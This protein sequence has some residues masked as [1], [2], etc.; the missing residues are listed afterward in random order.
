[1]DKN[2]LIKKRVA[3]EILNISQ[4]ILD[5]DEYAKVLNY[6]NTNRINDLRLFI[7]EKM[8]FYDTLS[9]IDNEDEQIKLQ[10]KLC[11]KLENIIMEEF[12]ENV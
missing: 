11:D 2:I 9:I 10:L 1:M 6:I 4:S 12:L 3:N 7:S 5:D 8:E